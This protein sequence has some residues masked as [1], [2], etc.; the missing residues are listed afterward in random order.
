VAE[1]TIPVDLN[2]LSSWVILELTN[3]KFEL[4][5]LSRKGGIL[6]VHLSVIKRL[7]QS[8]KI[9]LRNRSVK[10]KIKTLIK[11]VE[12]SPSLDQ[13]RVNLRKAVSLLDKAARLKV[14]HKKTAARIKTRLAREVNKLP[15]SSEKKKD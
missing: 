13:A 3:H 11:E 12:T 4:N 1:L 5:C 2:I 14:M 8:R 9:N 6:A 10:S 15:P 7:K